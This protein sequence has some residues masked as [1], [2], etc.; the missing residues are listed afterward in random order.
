MVNIEEILH[1][2]GI[3][4]RIGELNNIIQ[5]QIYQNNVFYFLFLIN[6]RTEKF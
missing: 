1:R 5:K 3:E 6:M 4:F 2:V